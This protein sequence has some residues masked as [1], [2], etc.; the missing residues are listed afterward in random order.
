VSG[1]Q[2]RFV[3]PETVNGPTDVDVTYVVENTGDPTAATAVGKIKVHITPAPGKDNP[4]QAPTPRQLD[5]RVVQ[6][7]VL[8]LKLPP[9]GLDPDGDS[10]AVVGIDTAPKLG[11]VLAYGANSISFQAYPDVQGTDEFTY[12]VTDRYGAT[13][14]GQ[15]RVGVVQ[16]APP[17]TARD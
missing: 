6:G 7:D 16:R 8:T 10:V 11:R 5:G 4:N 14:T 9:T 13:A 12:T 2:V 3:A 17:R 1:R 15:V